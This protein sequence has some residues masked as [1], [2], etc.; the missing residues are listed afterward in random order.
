M[1]NAEGGWKVT[2]HE[3]FPNRGGCKIYSSC[4]VTVPSSSTVDELL[5]ALRTC[6]QNQDPDSST[7]PGELRPFSEKLVGKRDHGNLLPTNPD[8]KPNCSWDPSPT[9]TIGEAGLCDGAVLCYYTNRL[10][11]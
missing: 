10:E 1:A 8:A 7:K 3:L 9:K 6:P 11:D 5:K 2:V 4:S